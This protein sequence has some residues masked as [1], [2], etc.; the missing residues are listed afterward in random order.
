MNDI[1]Y[2]DP[3]KI[4]KFLKGGIEI[5][6]LFQFCLK[7]QKK[8]KSVNIRLTQPGSFPWRHKMSNLRVYKKLKLI[9]PQ[10]WRFPNSSAGFVPR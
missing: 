6:N 1:R 2:K 3:Q 9:C 7:I 5:N 4:N 8:F 10:A